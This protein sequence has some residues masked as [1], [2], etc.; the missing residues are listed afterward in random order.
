MLNNDEML[1]DNNRQKEDSYIHGFWILPT[2]LTIEAFAKKQLMNYVKN[3]R[4]EM[5]IFK[6]EKKF[7]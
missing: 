2:W 6:W 4:L 3:R 7:A 1:S 5:D